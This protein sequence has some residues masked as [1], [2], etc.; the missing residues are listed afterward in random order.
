MERFF[1]GLTGSLSGT[2][3][4]MN[5]TDALDTC[6]AAVTKL[7]KMCCEP[8]RSPRLL[9]VSDTLV[10]VRASVA[11]AEHDPSVIEPTL[12][13]LQELGGQIG[14]LQVACCAPARM[15]HYARLLEGFTTIQIALNQMRGQGH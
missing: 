3:D 2:V 10:G 13:E 9:A 6:D 8:D 1:L 12:A 11:E 5:V 4:V 7:H 15:P 14:Q